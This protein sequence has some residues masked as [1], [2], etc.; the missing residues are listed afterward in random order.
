MQRS[1][2]SLN[3]LSDEPGQLAKKIRAFVAVWYSLDQED[4]TLSVLDTQVT[5]RPVCIGFIPTLGVLHGGKL[6]DYQVAGPCAFQRLIRTAMYS[7]S[8][9]KWS[10]RIVDS[11]QVLFD[12]VAKPG[13]AYHSNSVSGHDCSKAFVDVAVRSNA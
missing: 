12:L 11:P 13:F 6:N 2:V 10:Q 3:E 5:N 8:A 1:G 9:G 7:I 4:V